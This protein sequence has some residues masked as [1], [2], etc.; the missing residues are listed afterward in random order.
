MTLLQSG[1]AKSLAEAAYTIDQSVRIAGDTSYLAKTFGSGGDQQKWT[2]SFWIKPCVREDYGSDPNLSACFLSSG[3]NGSNWQNLAWGYGGGVGPTIHYS[4]WISNVNKGT[5]DSEAFYRDY[6]SWYHIVYA[7]DSTQ[8]SASDRLKIYMNG[9]Q[10]TDWAAG[11][12]DITLNVS[13]QIN[14][15]VSHEIGRQGYGGAAWV[16]YAY[17]AEYMF[18]DSQ[19]LG[20]ENWGESNETTGQWVPIE[21]EGTFGAT[22]FYLDFAD[23]TDFGK[24]VSGEGND[25][26]S[27]SLSGWEQT[28]DSP[29][30]NLCTM[31]P[32]AVNATGTSPG[33]DL[34]NLRYQ[35]DGG[36]SGNW[37]GAIA[38]TFGMTSGKWYWESYSY[39]TN[40]QHFKVGVTDELNNRTA[41]NTAATF[42]TYGIGYHGGTSGQGA[43]TITPS[44][45]G[46]YISGSDTGQQLTSVVVGYAYDAENGDFYVRKGEDSWVDS[47]WTETSDPDVA[48]VGSIP[49]TDTMYIAYAGYDD[50]TNTSHDI[51]NFGQDSSF[52]GNVTAQGNQDGNSIGDFYYEPP[53]GYLA[54][55]ASNLS[56]PEI[57]DPTDH[58]NT[59]AY[60]G[61]GNQAVTGVGFQPDFVWVKSRS[62]TYN[63]QAHDAVRGATA[64]ALWP[65]LTSAE[66]PSYAFDSFDSDGF[67]TDSGNIVGINDSGSTYAAWNWKGDGV[68]GGTL[69]EDGTIDSQVNVNTTAGFSIATYTGQVAA[70]TV[71]HGLAQAPELVMGKPRNDADAWRVGS[72]F[73]TSWVYYLKLNDTVAETS[74]SAIWNSLAPTADVF[75]VGTDGVNGVDGRTYVAYCFHSVE[76]YSKIGSYVGNGDADGAFIYCGF[77]PSLFLVKCIDTAST[78]WLM[79]DNKRDPYNVTEQRLEPDTNDAEDTDSNDILDFVSNG[80]K[81]RGNGGGLNYGSRVQIYMAFAESPFKTAN[82]R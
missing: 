67:T 18:I 39:A 8:T 75:N 43:F 81:L 66:N 16:L 74:Y 56:D 5:Y 78:N 59:I 45:T 79:Y 7:F 41:Y 55:C 49:T 23:S 73:L 17:L 34:G 21:Y 11:G 9:T 38:S 50:G 69:N 54:L 72:D 33:F 68:A 29:T 3:T 51:F 28:L 64:G 12:T 1:V 20:P 62:D 58:F 70:G 19:Q 36:L 40:L 27:Y 77:R 47:S 14:S 31:N 37:D 63:H 6:A 30:S 48:F 53:S 26:T 57:A 13:G 82:A 80:I 15:A 25:W 61:D 42:D 4:N 60:S 35:V 65:D 76:G 10:I 24:D 71:G 32:L 22:S 44:T 52:A 2:L 46:G